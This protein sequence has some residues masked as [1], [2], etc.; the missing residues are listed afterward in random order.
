MSYTDKVIDINRPNPN[1]K[2]MD[3]VKRAAR[4]EVDII[5]EGTP[6][7]LKAGIAMAIYLFLVNIFGGGDIVAFKFIKYLFL[8]IPLWIGL[9]KVSNLLKTGTVFKNGILL[10]SVIT[11]V[12]GLTLALMNILAFFINPEVSFNKFS[13][14]PETA[15]SMLVISGSVFFEVLVFGMIITFI[16]LQILKSKPKNAIT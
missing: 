16:W 3:K 8:A 7:G 14:E 13:L 2:E 12:S 5:K 4:A 9:S 15:K 1:V 11:F 6:L 10:G